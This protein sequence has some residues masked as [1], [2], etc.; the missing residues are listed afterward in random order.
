MAAGG[1][2][3]L[4]HHGQIAVQMGQRVQADIVSGLPELLPAL[5]AELFD[6]LGP[7][8]QGRAGAVLRRR[9][10]CR[11]GIAGVCPKI[12]PSGRFRHAAPPWARI[13]MRCIARTSEFAFSRAAADVDETPR[14]AHHHDLGAAGDDV[15]HLG[16]QHRLGHLGVHDAED[17]AE[18]AAGFGLVERDQIQAP[19]RPEQLLLFGADAQSARQVAGGM[20]DDPVGEGGPDV[21]DLQDIDEE[22]AEFQDTRRDPRRPAD[23]PPIPP[24]T[25]PGSGA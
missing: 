23:A 10:D 7:F 14:F 19:D 8:A 17:P 16:L 3:L 12:D 1:G 9:H 2:D 6:D 18:A 4:L 5:L 22:L 20:A 21:R 15:S 13:S 24:G 11:R 25:S